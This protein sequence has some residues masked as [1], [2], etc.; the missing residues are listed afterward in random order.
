MIEWLVILVIVLCFASVCFFGS[1]FVP[2]KKEWAEDALNL[3]VLSKNDLVVDLGAGNGKILRLLSRKG[4]RSIG[5]ELNPLLALFSKLILYKNSDAK[6]KMKNYWKIDLP[7]ETT[8]VYAFMVERDAKKL[9]QYLQR[10]IKIVK[11]RKIKLITFGFNLPNKKAIKQ[12][13]GARLYIFE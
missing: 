1:P 12:T 6:I 2:T 13:T 11:T 3:V 10:Q 4:I 9:E 7:A 8:V 5:Y